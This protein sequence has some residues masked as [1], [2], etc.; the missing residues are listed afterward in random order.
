MTREHRSFFFPV[1]FSL[2]LHILLLAWAGTFTLSPLA[3]PLTPIKVMILQKPTPLPVGE[4]SGP[5]GGQTPA[6]AKPKPKI[7]K[8]KPPKP[9]KPKPKIARRLHK[10]KTPPPAESEQ[11]AGT[12]L[13]VEEKGR[14]P[15]GER[16]TGTGADREG[17]TDTGKEGNGTGGGSPSGKGAGGGGGT[18]TRPDYAIN[19]KPLYPLLARRMGAEGV[20]VL[21]VLVREDGSVGEARVRKSSGFELLDESALRTVR[22]KWRFLPARRNGKP[23]ESWVEVPIR[24]VLKG[25]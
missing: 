10:A 23:V 22:D 13:K 8:K 20:V 16:T 1:L 21:Q 24:F 9:T 18:L 6:P 19:P 17:A 3:R 12:E 4:P 2:C 7:A 11:R 14:S 5:P 25:S 15:S